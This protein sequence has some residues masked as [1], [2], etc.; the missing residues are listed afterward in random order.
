MIERCVA[1]SLRVEFSENLAQFGDQS[2]C[3]LQNTIGGLFP[4]TNILREFNFRNKHTSRAGYLNASILMNKNSQ[5]GDI[6]ARQLA[7]SHTQMFNS[8]IIVHDQ[9]LPV[10]IYK[11]VSYCIQPSAPIVVFCVSL[12]PLVELQ[13]Y[14]LSS[15][16]ATNV[17]IE[18]LWTREQ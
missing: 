7:D 1:Y 16:E 6:V 3:Q 5:S 18:E 2:T 9:F 12:E 4:K 8:C 15:R 10:E 17:R 13:E 14:L 11:V